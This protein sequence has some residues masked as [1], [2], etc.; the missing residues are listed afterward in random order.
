MKNNSPIRV[1][2]VDDHA[3]VRKG[4]SA[5][6]NAFDDLE[7]VGESSNGEDALRQCKELQP[8]V[9]LMDLVMPGMDGVSA[10]SA[11]RKSCPNTQVIILTSYNEEERVQAAL[12]AGAIGY[13]LKDVLAD[14]LVSAIRGAN[15]G[16]LSLTSNLAKALI[17]ASREPLVANPNLTASEKEVLVLMIEGLSNPEI[18]KRLSISISTVRFHVSNILSK[19]GVLSRT[20][21]VSAAVQNKLVS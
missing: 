14:Q 11:I 5:F 18:A 10:T 4:L 17:H 6:L 2:I 8:D 3:V 13:L 1:L 15:S 9:V 19:M 7:L 12:K 21:A 20:A 16:V